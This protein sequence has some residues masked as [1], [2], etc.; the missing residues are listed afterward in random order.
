LYTRP[1]FTQPIVALDPGSR[2]AKYRLDRRL[3][4]GGMGEVFL[5]HDTLLDRPVAIKFLVS[6]TDDQARRRLL[7]EARIRRP[8]PRRAA[9]SQRLIVT[10]WSV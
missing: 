8:S 7:R 9:H 6:P 4:T 3:G 5:A 1:G 2:I 10:F